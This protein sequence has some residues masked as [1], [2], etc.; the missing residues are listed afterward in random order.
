MDVFS[1][2]IVMNWQGGSGKSY[3][4]DSILTTFVKGQ[5]LDE[6]CYLKLATTGKAACLIRGYNIHSDQFGMDILMGSK[7]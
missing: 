6:D 2:L 7:N 5:G 4:I 1:R 3:T